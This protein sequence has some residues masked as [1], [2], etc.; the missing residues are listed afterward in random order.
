MAVKTVNLAEDA[1][2]L[3]AAQKREGESFS[4]VVRRLA[5][6]QSLLTPFAGAWAGMPPA[7]LQRVRRFLREGDRISREKLKRLAVASVKVG[8]PG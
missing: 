1:Y 8:Q 4:D 5:G 7:T 3:L 2:N 6:S